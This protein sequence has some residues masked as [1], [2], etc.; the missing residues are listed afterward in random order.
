MKIKLAIFAVV[1]LSLCCKAS[2]FCGSADCCKQKACLSCCKD[3]CR[4]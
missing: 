4:C 1:V 3:K 2:A